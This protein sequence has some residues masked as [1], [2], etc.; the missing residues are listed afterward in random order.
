MEEE[1]KELI[2]SFEQD[3]GKRVFRYILSVSENDETID[4]DTR[5]YYVIAKDKFD[6][7]LVSNDDPNKI[8]SIGIGWSVNSPYQM[9]EIDVYKDNDFRRIILNFFTDKEKEDAINMIKEK[10]YEHVNK[11]EWYQSNDFIEKVNTSLCII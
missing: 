7:Y 1:V 5:I 6:Y 10:F 11:K 8:T 2:Q 4:F 3:K 9:N